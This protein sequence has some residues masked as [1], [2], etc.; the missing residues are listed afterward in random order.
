M[1]ELFKDWIKIVCSHY[2]TMKNPLRV[3]LDD[4][5]CYDFNSR[6]FRETLHR[7]LVTHSQEFAGYVR[8]HTL[9]KKSSTSGYQNLSDKGD[10]HREE[11][12]SLLV[13]GLKSEFDK[14]MRPSLGAS[15]E[16]CFGENCFIEKK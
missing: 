5:T 13:H 4:M 9:S 3:D 7:H 14:F 8:T 15:S 6:V 10:L 12:E 2:A 16:E 1:R 11:L